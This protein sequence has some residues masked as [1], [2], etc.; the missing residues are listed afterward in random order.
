MIISVS[1]KLAAFPSS[2]I[3]LVLNLVPPISNLLRDMKAK[4]M[5]LPKNEL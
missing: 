2:S 3:P 1:T 5:V 4:L